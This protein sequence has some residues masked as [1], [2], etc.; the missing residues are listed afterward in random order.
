MKS[1]WPIRL[2]GVLNT[3]LAEE[4]AVAIDFEYGKDTNG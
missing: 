1:Y 4:S 3:Y 2:D